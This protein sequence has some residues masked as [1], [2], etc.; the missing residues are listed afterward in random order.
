MSF[1]FRYWNTRD[2]VAAMSQGTYYV[3][4]ARPGTKFVVVSYLFKN[5]STVQQQTPGVNSGEVTTKPNGYVYKLWAVPTGPEIDQYRPN[6]A[7]G[8]DIA[9][10]G[11]SSGGDAKLLP[12]ESVEGRAIFEMPSEMIP[13]DV[14]LPFLPVRISLAE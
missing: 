3:F 7:L 4:V 1:T 10:T 6:L 11:A 14:T 2:H 9:E 8:R 5:D 12:G 13:V